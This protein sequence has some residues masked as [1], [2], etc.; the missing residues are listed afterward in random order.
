MGATMK[1]LLVAA[2]AILAALIPARA[3]QSAGFQFNAATSLAVSGVSSNVALPGT[4]SKILLQNTGGATAYLNF[5]NS[6]VVATTTGM[7]LLGGECFY[8]QSP[9]TYSYIGGIT[10]SSTTTVLMTQG[11]GNPPISCAPSITGGTGGTSSSFGAA[12]PSAGTALGASQGGNMVALNELAGNLLVNCVVGCAGGTSSNASDAVATSSTNGQALSW[13]YG[14]NG[15]TWDRLQ[16]DASKFLKVNCAA[17]CGGSGSVSN[18]TSG[19]ATSSTNTG[20]VSWLYGWN[21]TTWDQVKTSSGNLAVVFASAQAVTQSGTWNVGTVTTL[22]A[23][24]FASPQA[25]TQSGTWTDTV[26]QGTAANLNATVVGTGTFLVQAAESGVWNITNVTGTVS[27]PT[28]AATAAN[29]ASVIGAAPGTAA[30]NSML[31]G[32]VFNT[33]PP[34]LTT[35]QQGALQ[36]DSAGNLLINIKA[37]GSVGNV[38]N[39]SSGVATSA[40]NLGTVAY[41]YGFNGTTWDQLQTDASKNLKISGGVAQGSTTSGQIGSP[42]MAATTAAPPSYT[43]AQTNLLSLDL[44]GNLRVTSSPYGAAMVAETASAT[45]TTA[46][47]VATLAAAAGKTTYICGFTITADATSLT[48]GAATVTGTITGT[49]NYIQSVAAVT[50]GASALNQ[51]YSPCIPASATNTTIVVTSAAAGTGGNTAVAAWGFQL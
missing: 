36:L 14:F 24:T 18:A 37:G 4:G 27:L 23:I 32:G 9:G 20:A 48:T 22:P 6:S 49:L 43:T 34:T 3:Q 17:G 12:F 26:T 29:Q 7:P 19:V 21:G 30:T 50:S 25:V 46:A 13:N 42:I 41:T 11:E 38:S 44:S 51:N 39:A 2:F 35:T 47:T 5:G 33:T 1:R 10:S 8:V 15:T 45:G 31:M 40:T 16:V 28:G